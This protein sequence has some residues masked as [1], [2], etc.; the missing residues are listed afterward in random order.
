MDIFSLFHDFA[1]ELAKDNAEDFGFEDLQDYYDNYESDIFIFD[2]LVEWVEASY[3]VAHNHDFEWVVDGFAEHLLQ[4]FGYP[5]GSMVPQ[6]LALNFFKNVDNI[7]K[8]FK[9]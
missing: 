2:T 6:V 9:R 1:N 7:E 3:L 8:A 4:T 5:V